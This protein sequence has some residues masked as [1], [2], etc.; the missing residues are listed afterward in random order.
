MKRLLM[1][2]RDTTFDVERMEIISAKI[3]R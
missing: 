3:K 1:K 2:R